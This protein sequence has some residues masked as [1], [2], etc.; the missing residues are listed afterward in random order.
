MSW[1]KFDTVTPDKPEVHQLA[2]MLDLDPDAV[3]G[4]LL[5]VWIWFDQHT[6]DGHADVTMM[7][8]LDRSVGHAGFCKAMA[9]VGWL[10]LEGNDMHLPRFDRHNGQS[11]KNRALAAERK[12]KQRQSV[13]DKSRLKRDT[14]VTREE[15]IREEYKERGKFPS[16]SPRSSE[17]KAS[18]ARPESVEAVVEYAKTRGLP[19]SDGEYFYDSQ[20]AGGWLRNGKSIK[21]WKACFRSWQSG[22]YLP[23]LKNP[24]RAASH[25]SPQMEAAP[26][27]W[28][29]ELGRILIDGDYPQ[30]TL[31]SFNRGDKFADWAGLD[32]D[33]QQAIKLRLKQGEAA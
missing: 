1:L 9:D 5:R 30:A 10:T 16:S 31:D 17:A 32:P 27:R 19:V 20:E 6:E 4:K 22:G 2:G 11:A 33:M 3:V 15:K 14:A 13:T 28:R 29:D 18:K 8:H 12:R 23:S 7:S 24:S 26:E 25:D 21:D